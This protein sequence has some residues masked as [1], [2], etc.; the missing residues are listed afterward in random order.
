MGLLRLLFGG[1]GRRVR[2][3]QPCRCGRGTIRVTDGRFGAFLGC[4]EYRWNRTGCNYAWRLDGRRLP[5]NR[6]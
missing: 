6:R 4:S 5:R 2:P 1:A 3:G